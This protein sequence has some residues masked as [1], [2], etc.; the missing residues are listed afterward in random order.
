MSQ[1]KL[2]DLSGVS[3]Q[4]ISDCE[5]GASSMMPQLRCFFQSICRRTSEV[6]E[7][8]DGWLKGQS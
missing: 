7:M 4:H 3:Q 6:A 1:Q 5:R 2:A 8:Q